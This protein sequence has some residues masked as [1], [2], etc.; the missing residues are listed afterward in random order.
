MKKEIKLL[1]TGLSSLL[2][3]DPC[4]AKICWQGLTLAVLSEG[5]KT[6]LVLFSPEER[7]SSIGQSLW[8]GFEQDEYNVSVHWD[9]KRQGFYTP[10]PN[11]LYHQDGDVFPLPR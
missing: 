4:L 9:I 11:S 7:S 2:G 3:A 8:V 5:F 1:N 6:R 10:I